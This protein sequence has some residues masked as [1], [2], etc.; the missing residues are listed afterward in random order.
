MSKGVHLRRYAANV[1]T[2]R[3][4]GQAPLPELADDRVAA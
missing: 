4:T 2:P 3:K 1:S